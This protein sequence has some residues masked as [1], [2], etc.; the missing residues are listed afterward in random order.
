MTPSIAP[1]IKRPYLIVYG[2]IWPLGVFL[3]CYHLISARRTETC[4]ELIT[5]H[6]PNTAQYF[7]DVARFPLYDKISCVIVP[8]EGVYDTIH[9]DFRAI[10][11]CPAESY[12]FERVQNFLIAQHRIL[13]NRGQSYHVSPTVEHR[14][15]CACAETTSCSN[16]AFWWSQETENLLVQ[17]WKGKPL[18]CW[19]ACIS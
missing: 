6:R 11:S 19:F 8:C 4:G 12:S 14:R 3:Y 15:C 9:H 10:G 17:M 18:Q 5:R 16:M 1:S 13:K 7:Y 2:S